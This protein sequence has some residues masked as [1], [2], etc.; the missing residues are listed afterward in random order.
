MSTLMQHTL[1][2]L[3]MECL[4]KSVDEVVAYN[5]RRLREE[6]GLSVA[7]L[8]ERLP[9]GRHVVYDYERPRQGSEQRQF[10]WKE[11]F[12]LCAVLDVT[13]FELVLPPAGVDL[14]HFESG[15]SVQEAAERAD[16]GELAS[17]RMDARTELAFIL[18]GVDA[19]HVQPA[20]LRKLAEKVDAEHSRRQ[21]IIAGITEEM[22]HRLD[23]AIDQMG[24]ET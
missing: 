18:F 7:Q 5:V 11:I 21:E 1:Q 10:L 3:K 8:A 22:L 23:E 6:K 12:F 15:R 2:S 17:L 16:L 13:L 4:L 14:E 9:V 20:V 24:D 19:K